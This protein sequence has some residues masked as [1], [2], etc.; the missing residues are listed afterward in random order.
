M[1]ATTP[2]PPPRRPPADPAYEQGL[3]ANPYAERMVLGSI[4]LN[5]AKLP[6]VL[7]TLQVD[8][9]SLEK[10]RKIY[11]R[12]ADLQDAGR[13]VNRITVYE[14][15]RRHGE[16]ESVD[17]LTYL[18]SLDDGLPELYNL[19][20]YIAIVREKAILRRT[21]ERS[22]EII[23]LCYLSDGQPADVLQRAHDSLG[24][25]LQQTETAS[26]IRTAAEVVRETPSEVWLMRETDETQISHPWPSLA[27]YI[28]HF[29]GG[30]MVTIAAP[31][32]AGKSSFARQ[33]AHYA[34]LCGVAT[35]F[36]TLE[37]DRVEVTRKMACSSVGISVSDLERGECTAEQI[38]ALSAALV[39][40]EGLPLWVDDADG[41]TPARLDSS[42]KRMSRRA[43]PQLVIVDYLQLLEMPSK[44]DNRTTEV[45]RISRYLQRMSKR[46]GACVVCLAQLNN[47]G[48]AAIERGE[49][50]CGRHLRESGTI[51]HDSHSVLFLVPGEKPEEWR[52]G[53]RYRL[54]I[55]KNRGGPRGRIDLH[56]DPRVTRFEET[57]L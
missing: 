48:V 23:Q 7:E 26:P 28:P 31:S 9:F 53:I 34:A 25:L 54:W 47:D 16:A 6:M 55:A 4:L 20:D 10:H 46:W 37:E 38:G 19:E 5:D 21:I 41:A 35:A 29:R 32:S 30:R 42:L 45:S 56:F 18:V 22:Q 8:D 51:F 24:D 43:K 2:P 36:F 57:M 14:E 1:S 49:E 3:P 40:L 17:G 44:S 39:G 27:Q 11:R 52:N 15:L 12:M 33:L 13:H 50:P